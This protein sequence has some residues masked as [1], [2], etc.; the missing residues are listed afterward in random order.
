MAKIVLVDFT[1]ADKDRLIAEKYDVDLRQTGWMTG[2]DNP[3]DLPGDTEVVFYQIGGEA[4]AGGPDLHADVHE[5]LVGRVREGAR[6]VC[7]IG[8]GETSR[9]TNIVGPVDG[10]EIKESAR[11]DAIV[12]NPRA[13]FH[14]PFE[15]FKPF[16][17]KSFRLLPEKFGEGVWEKDSPVNGKLEFLAKT[18][19]GA[20]VAIVVR[21][22]KGYLLLLP[23]FGPKNV[24][25][26]DYILKDKLPLTSEIS[27][28]SGTDWLEGDEYVFPEL[29]ALMARRDEEKKK[30]DDLL[31]DYDR[32]IKDLKTGGQEEFHHLLSGEGAGL[33]KAVVNAFRYLGWGRVV[34]V[35]QY[36]KNTIRNKEE[37]AWVIDP[38]DMPVEGGLRKGEL[39]II[40]ARGGKNW[41]TDDECALLQK[42]KG[43][44]MQEFDNTRMKA[45]LVGNYFS[46]AEAKS[47][48]NPFSAA[49]I[50]EAQ[51]DGNGLL[52]SYELFRA[53]KAEKENR[54]S[55]DAIRDQIKL[56]TGLITFDI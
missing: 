27:D 17:A 11:A 49:Q 28:A 26:A 45:V 47:R 15:R 13:L 22:G 52:T 29:K 2:L 7:F 40:L 38:A 24:E 8:G 53:I 33:K 10:L 51:K 6:V 54:I 20:P 4:A 30:L 48:P 50:E 18:A 16:I 55:K 9:L 3:L 12:F 42:F 56:K 5:A 44:R 19:D 25:I 34:D 21:K 14:V 41:A 31:A 35:D 46:A 32:Q 43:R 23:S 36:W 1:Q 39:V 37:D